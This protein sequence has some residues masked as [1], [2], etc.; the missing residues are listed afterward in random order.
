M[1]AVRDLLRDLAGRGCT[2]FL[3]SHLLAE[4]SE[5]CTHVGVLLGGRLVSEGPIPADLEQ[6]YLDMTAGVSP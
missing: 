3:S 6:H 1:K 2:I 4:V 5:I